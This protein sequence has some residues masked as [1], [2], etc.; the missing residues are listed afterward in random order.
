MPETA[1]LTR[2]LPWTS[3]EFRLAIEAAPTAMV[4][5]D[6]TGQIVLVNAHTAELFGYAREE[7]VGMR[8]EQ[9]VPER[10]RARHPAFRSAYFE[11]PRARLMGAGRDLHALRKDGS[12]VPVEIGLNP[13]DTAEGRFV[14]SSIIDITERKRSL[15]QFRM[16]IE[17]AP[18]GMIMVDRRGTIVLVNAHVEKLFGYTREELVGRSMEV[19]VPERFRDRHPA[20]RNAFSAEPQARPMG[21]GRDLFGL[22]KDGSE[23][24][25][26]IALNPLRTTAGEFVLSSVA[27][28]TERK[29]AERERETM[30]GELQRLN[31]ELEGRV[32]VRTAELSAALR[33]REILLQE[34]HHRVKNNLQII[35]SLVNMQ[36]RKLEA[37]PSRDA[38]REC[39][40]RVQAIALIH[41]RLYQSQDYSRVPLSDYVRSLAASVFNATGTAL[42][43]VELEFAIDDVSLTVDKAIPCGL[44]LNE[45]ITNA[46]KHAFRDGRPG[47][48][49]VELVR[50]EGGLIRLAV[51]DDGVGLPADFQKQR[52]HSLG[53]QLVTTL[54]EQLDASLT[55]S[56]DGGASFELEFA[57]S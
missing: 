49:L 7:L 29:R 55:I 27:D 52:G 38:L 39:Q 47:R 1:V 19:L 36:A 26:E 33:D 44:V 9:L 56:S 22:R 48:L 4:L 18:T 31:A 57:A 21:A 11:E 41:E 43:G 13:I 45:L 12:E 32:E 46:L 5:I 2:P 16:A 34:V 10:S 51:R 37:G 40:T 6:Q 53:I 8:V 42:R 17:A 15:E 30:L 28:I 25:L 54:A 35:S 50:T 3:P 14:L 23:V 24:P 20:Y